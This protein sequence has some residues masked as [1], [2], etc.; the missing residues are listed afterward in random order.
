[1]K[2]FAII[3]APVFDE[4]DNRR[5]VRLFDARAVSSGAAPGR[6]FN[7]GTDQILLK[8]LA[9]RPPGFSVPAAHQ[10]KRNSSI[11]SE[12]SFVVNAISLS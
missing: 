10:R 6:Q 7:V 11:L 3:F 9:D 4:N 2:R 12:S 5:R 8:M 1:M